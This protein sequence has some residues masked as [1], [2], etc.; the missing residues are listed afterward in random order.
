MANSVVSVLGRCEI[1]LTLKSE[2]MLN[3]NLTQAYAMFPPESFS[4]SWDFWQL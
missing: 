2:N 1:G 4:P 3:Q